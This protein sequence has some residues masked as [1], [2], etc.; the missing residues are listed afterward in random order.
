MLEVKL[1][2]SVLVAGIAFA[3]SALA[4]EAVPSA[5]SAPAAPA[6][7]ASAP[8]V[9]A[10]AVSAPA[11]SAPVAAAETAKP[12]EQQ[13]VLSQAEGL[14]LLKKNNCVVCHSIEKKIVGPAYKD[15]A[16]KYRGQADAEA[17]LVTKVTKGGKGVWGA[18][19][20]PPQTAKQ[21]DIKSLVR[22]IL[23]LK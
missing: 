13:P 23:S 2:L 1:N 11:V 8:A 9:S 7:A 20:M 21:E 5:A 3:G 17:K 12:V 10:P 4:G 6:P 16:A 14:A 18:V 22:F 19:A 15:V